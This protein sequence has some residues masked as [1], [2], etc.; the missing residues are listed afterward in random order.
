[1]FDDEFMRPLPPIV[2]PAARCSHLSRVGFFE[3][4]WNLPARNARFGAFPA[5]SAHKMAA[6]G[7]R[8]IWNLGLKKS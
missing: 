7:H 6:F 2:F 4:A 3:I 1:V 5:I 8:E